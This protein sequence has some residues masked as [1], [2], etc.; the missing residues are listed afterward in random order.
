MVDRNVLGTEDSV[1]SSV[2]SFL[3]GRE[4]SAPRFSE[5]FM[6]IITNMHSLGE[7]STEKFEELVSN[8]L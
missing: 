5:P 4:L 6:I 7:A 1:I 3:D 2:I 8:R